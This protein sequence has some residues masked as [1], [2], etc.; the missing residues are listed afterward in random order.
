ML[1]TDYSPLII[2]W[3]ALAM[4]CGG[5]IK[6][7][8]G[9]G[10]P[11]LTVPMMAMVLPPQMA[12]VLMA[13]PVVV[14]NVWLVKDAGDLKLTRNRFWP[15]LVA[16]LIGT[17]VGVKVLKGID[18]Q[19]LLTVV[20]I[21]V[22][23]FPLLQGS[24]K[25]ILILPSWEKPMGII[26]CGTAGVIGGLSSM[27]GPM[28]ILYLVSLTNLNKHQFVGTICY[29][30]IVAVIPWVLVMFVL[31]VLNTPY[32]ISSALAVLPLSVGLLAGQKI[33]KH[34]NEA[35]FKNLVLII[36]VVSGLGMLWRA[37]SYSGLQ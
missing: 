3:C 11:L 21:T 17:W 18:E 2:A 28:L 9:V 31:G 20:G 27:F 29:F 34:I 6:G 35:L 30:Y 33:R 26:F 22:I 7:A 25:K 32:A 4:I 36:L 15:A 16:L 10:T 24:P 23:C 14:A 19:L 12:I 5:F 37:W 1:I 8:L 13:I